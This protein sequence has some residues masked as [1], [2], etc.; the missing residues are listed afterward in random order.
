MALEKPAEVGDRGETKGVRHLADRVFTGFQ[1][2]FGM[3]EQYIIPVFQR[4]FP[5]LLMKQAEITQE[6]R[7]CVRAAIERS[8]NTDSRSRCLYMQ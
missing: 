3:S 6:D 7:K 8:E 4:S 2:E 5:E 1:Q